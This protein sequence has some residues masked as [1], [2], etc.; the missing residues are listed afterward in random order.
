MKIIK[1]KKSLPSKFF[2]AYSNFMSAETDFIDGNNSILETD[3][4]DISDSDK[5][6]IR[7]AFS[8]LDKAFYN[9]ERVMKKYFDNL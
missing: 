7:K 8:D 1:E 5:E 3:Y 6:F 4:S 9:W 2:K